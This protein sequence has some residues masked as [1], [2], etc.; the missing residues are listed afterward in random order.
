MT[1]PDASPSVVIVTYNSSAVIG[2]CLSSLARFEGESTQV[3]V[4]DN[5]ST[6][7][8]AELVEQAHP[9]VRL[10][11]QPA[12]R[13]FSAGVNAG[14]AATDSDYVLLLNPD[15]WLV[16]PIISDLAA[17]ISSD[18]KIGALGPKIL[19]EDGTLQPSCRRYPT[20]WSSLF[21]R[22]SLLTKLLPWNPV[23][24]HYLMTDFDHASA[25]DVDWLSCAAL[26]LR[27]TAFD[28]IGGMDESYFLYFEDVDL[29]HRIHDASYRVVYHPAV[30]VVHLISKSSGGVSNRT[31][32]ARHRAMWRY[33]RSYQGGNVAKDLVAGAAI[34]GR[35]GFYLAANSLSRPKP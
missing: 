17:A 8:T 10:L 3:V 4:V 20:V 22:T 35:A 18:P 34:A 27:R 2:E 30:S 6:D 29:C 21:N 5:A 1:A 32:L 28:E 33:W 16:S 14:V 13:G 11:R 26:L 7:G 31:I 15:S 25:R 12:N 23:T 19:N 9:W 24:R